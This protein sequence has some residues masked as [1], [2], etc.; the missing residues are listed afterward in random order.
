MESDV[1]VLSNGLR[2]KTII[3]GGGYMNVFT[4]DKIR[5]VALLGHGGSGKTSLVEALTFLAGMTNRMGSVDA[6]NTLSDF[7]KEEIKRKIQREA[8]VSDITYHL[9][10]ENLEFCEVSGNTVYIRS[11]KEDERALGYLNNK[12]KLYFETVIGEELGFIGC[13]V[14]IGLLFMIAIICILIARRAKDVGG[15]IIAGGMAGL[16]GIQT[17][18]NIGVVTGLLPNT[19]LTL[20]FVS[21]GL[22]SLIS[23]YAAIGF[24]LNVRLQSGR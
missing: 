19:G 21:Y 18:I 14:V 23:I 3:Y 20:P 11:E 1:T 13:C 8:A 9:W 15:Q 2:G 16:I 7:D 4:T 6:G 22:T 17:F 5:N 12:F 24:V 10:F